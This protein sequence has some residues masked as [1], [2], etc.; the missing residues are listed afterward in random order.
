MDADE[1]EK[2]PDL[3]ILGQ[4]RLVLLFDPIVDDRCILEY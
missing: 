4:M 2:L 3:E 1:S